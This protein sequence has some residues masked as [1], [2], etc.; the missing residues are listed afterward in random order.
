MSRNV[1]VSSIA[2]RELAGLPRSMDVQVWT[3]NQEGMRASYK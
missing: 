3:Y 2:E 1:P